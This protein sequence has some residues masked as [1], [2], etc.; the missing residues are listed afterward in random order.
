MASDREIRIHVGHPYHDA[1]ARRAVVTCLAGLIG[2]TVRQDDNRDYPAADLRADG[3]I[4]GL[5][6]VA[7]TYVLVR[8]ARAAHRGGQAARRAAR[9]PDH[10]GARQAP[11]GLAMGHRTRREAKA[12]GAVETTPDGSPGDTRRQGRAARRPRLPAADQ[13]CPPGAFPAG[14]GRAACPARQHGASRATTAP[15]V[16]AAGRTRLYVY[17]RFLVGWSR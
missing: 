11:R 5:H 3:T 6:A 10:R 2:G 15:V 4:G 7:E 14:H 8:R 12:P 16:A 9:R 17:T 13:R 1:A